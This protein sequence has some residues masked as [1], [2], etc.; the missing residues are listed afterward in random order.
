MAPT[1]VRW[2]E[3]FDLPNL[4]YSVD[5]VSGARRTQTY[6]FGLAAAEE[7]RG[8]PEEIVK[9]TAMAQ[10][11]QELIAEQARIKEDTRRLSGAF[12]GA[13]NRSRPFALSDRIA[14]VEDGLVRHDFYSV[15]ND[16]LAYNN[17]GQIIDKRTGRPLMTRQ[18][19]EA[20]IVKLRG[21]KK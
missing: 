16:Q 4:D 1:E 17:Q 12:Q 15:P 5:P 9:Q 2:V 18:E 6:E 19:A 20:K 3:T 7:P 10:K 14:S 8:V 21:R 13:G 11:Q